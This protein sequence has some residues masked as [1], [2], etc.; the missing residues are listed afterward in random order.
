MAEKKHPL[1]E[2][3]AETS[4]REK[5]PRGLGGLIYHNAF[6]LAISFIVALVSWFVVASNNAD[7]NV[8][9][10]DVPINIQLSPSAEAEGLRVFE[11]SY[12]EA[13][14]E[15]S[16]SSLI[17]SRLT[18]DDFS[19]TATLN[20]LSTKL[21]G[22]T[23]QRIQVPVEAVKT[24]AISDYTIETVS[25][26]EITVVYDR[27]KEVSLPLDTTEINYSVST[28]MFADTM[29]L[30]QDTVTVSGPESSVAQVSRA[31]LVATY[32]GELQK[33]TTFQGTVVLYDQEN[34]V[35]DLDDMATAPYL[36]VSTSQVDVTVPVLATKTVNLQASNL[37]H[38][39]AS[40]PDNRITVTPPSI[41]LTGTPESLAQVD[42]ILLDTPIDFADADL[43]RSEY[44]VD[45]PLPAGVRNL[46]ATG[47]NAVSQATVRLNLSGYGEAQLTV[48][49]ENISLINVPA[50]RKATLENTGLDVSVLGPQSPLSRV[51]GDNLGVQVDLSSYA[52][53][54]GHLQV[55]ATVSVAGE[56][57]GAC[58]VVGSY[59]VTVEIT[60]S[61][62]PTNVVMAGSGNAASPQQ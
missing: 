38:R 25:P 59:T 52:A 62:V 7:S 43:L 58:W 36:E 35:I 15:V 10:R 1:R 6:V 23:V 51:T 49:Q 48:P 9:I 34:R 3:E 8:L 13:D 19:V 37:L 39:P 56:S 40:F 41:T 14:L 33:D 57:G 4:R 20:P 29:V 28:G 18:P 47:D 11:M 44:V 31:A 53:Q 12:T 21:T 27:Y 55:P 32:D 5:R 16:G 17:T 61:S 22:N 50:G 2:E 60:E 42:T 54:T 30:S 24:S 26:E 45:I 46:N